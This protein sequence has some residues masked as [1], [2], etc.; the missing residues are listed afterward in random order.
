LGRFEESCLRLKKT[1]LRSVRQK[2]GSGPDETR[3]PPAGRCPSLLGFP[4]S[5]P[6]EQG[7]PSRRRHWKGINP[8]RRAKLNL[9]RR[10]YRGDRKLLVQGRKARSGRTLL[11]AVPFRM[12]SPI[13]GID[14]VSPN[15]SSRCRDRLSGGGSLQSTTHEQGALGGS[16]PNKDWGGLMTLEDCSSLGSSRVR[17]DSRECNTQPF[18]FGRPGSVRP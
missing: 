1:Y 16:T 12:A 13:V 9:Q 8:F 18:A 5:L 4:A 15:I 6:A 11:L 17:P 10:F 2:P 7:S 3:G 14:L